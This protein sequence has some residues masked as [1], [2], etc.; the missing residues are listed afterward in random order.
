[1][2]R[3]LTPEEKARNLTF[4][5]NDRFE[6]YV[7]DLCEMLSKLVNFTYEFS[8]VKDN[9]FGNKGIKFITFI[10]EYCNKVKAFNYLKYL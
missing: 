9:K 3:S 6:G 8:L 7:V 5:G 4:T 10:K 1:M 2:Y